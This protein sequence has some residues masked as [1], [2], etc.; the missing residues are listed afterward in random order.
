MAKRETLHVSVKFAMK[1]RETMQNYTV[2]AQK[3]KRPGH[4]TAYECQ[5]CNV[6]LCIEPCF[7]LFHSYQEYALAYKRWKSA[8]QPTEED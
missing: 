6:S 4:E 7:R 2:S 5:V 3:R 1:L 8:N